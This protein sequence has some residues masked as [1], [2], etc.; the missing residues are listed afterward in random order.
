MISKVPS[1]SEDIMI[2][3]E[4][5]WEENFDYV[6]LWTESSKMWQRSLYLFT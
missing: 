4:K 6:G 3:I 1:D 5:Q 2:L